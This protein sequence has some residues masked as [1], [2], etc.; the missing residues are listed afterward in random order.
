MRTTA[1]RRLLLAVVCSLTAGAAVVYLYGP[2][3]TEPFY[4]LTALLVMLAAL[5]I[6]GVCGRWYLRKQAAKGNI[7]E[8]EKTQTNPTPNKP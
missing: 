4:W 2:N 7:Y 8:Q 6:A 3:P 5:G 1:L